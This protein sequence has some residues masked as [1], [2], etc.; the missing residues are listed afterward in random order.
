MTVRPLT[1]SQQMTLDAFAADHPDARV[2]GWHEQVDGPIIQVD[3]TRW[4]ITR[5]GA[6]REEPSL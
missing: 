1:P 5:R 6:L 3:A 2:I 4:V